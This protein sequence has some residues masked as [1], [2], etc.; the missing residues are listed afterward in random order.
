MRAS[1]S[2]AAA[3]IW[4]GVPVPRH[5]AAV[6]TSSRM[7]DRLQ[8]ICGKTRYWSSSN[9]IR[10]ASGGGDPCINPSSL[11][12]DALPSG[13]SIPSNSTVPVFITRPRPYLP[14]IHAPLR[15]QVHLVAF[16]D[17]ECGV[18]PLL[19]DHRRGTA[20]RRRRMRIGLD[21]LNALSLAHLASPHLHPAEIQPLIAGET[22]DHGRR[23]ARQ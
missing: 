14:N 18:E 22:I 19:I 20:H 10:F 15:R 2:R 9:R 13:Y 7:C 8:R 16:L 21:A 12:S 23:A 4:L 17:A 11:G 3:P 5:T 1:L 6:G